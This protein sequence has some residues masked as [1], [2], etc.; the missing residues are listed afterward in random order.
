VVGP[1]DSRLVPSV[2]TTASVVAPQIG[3]RAGLPTGGPAGGTVERSPRLHAV[4]GL[5]WWAALAV[6]GHHLLNVTTVPA[7]L[8]AVL[9]QGVLGVTFFFVLSGFVLVWSMRPGVRPREFYRRRFARIYPL[10]LVTLLLALPVF[11]SFHPSPEQWWVKPVSVGVLALS[12]P[13][14]QG[15]SRDPTVMYSGNPTAWTLTLEAFF[16][17]LFPFLALALRRTG[18]RGAGLVVVGLLT[19]AG[20]LR[21]LTQLDPGGWVAG[22]PFPVLRVDEFALG[23]A[24]AW[25][26]RLGWR[27]R[28]S[29]SL[30]A[31]VGAGWFALYLAL[32]GEHPHLP[33]ARAFAPYLPEIV[34]ALCGAMIVATAVAELRGRARWLGWRPVVVLGEWSFALYLV[35][36]MLIYVVL[37]TVGRLAAGPASLLGS[38]ALLVASVA[39][40]AVLHVAVER[41]L[42]RRLR[43]RSPTHASV[44]G[45]ASSS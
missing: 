2:P 37:G 14:L 10:H 25:A 15:W 42:E 28:L 3:S 12:V 16:Y 19:L 13:V 40:A 26:M 41:P 7:P 1:L 24:L 45:C 31:L 11:Y 9:Q 33:V 20:A 22:L 43:G 5:R 17:T 23:M 30:V 4:T 21:A 38:L 27:P 32:G 8:T 18:R 35:H 44:S 39:A 29:P 6:L 34:M 36:S